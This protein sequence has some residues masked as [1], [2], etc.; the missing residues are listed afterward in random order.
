[1]KSEV[2]TRKFYYLLIFLPGRIASLQTVE[3]YL[4]TAGKR[5]VRKKSL[6]PFCIG[7]NR[8]VLSAKNFSMKRLM[9][10]WLLI[11]FII[12]LP[13]CKKHRTDDPGNYKL[14]RVEYY[15]TTGTLTQW[16][17]KLSYSNGLV[18]QIDMSANS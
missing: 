1:M 15:D 10:Y 17:K 9:N 16:F 2:G 14:S 6:Q 12:M 13:A 11:V 7:I 5:L 3:M 4:Y 18:T 8:I